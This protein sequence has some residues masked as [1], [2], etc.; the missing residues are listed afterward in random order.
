MS[1]T[2]YLG[3]E[4]VGGVMTHHLEATLPLEALRLVEP[5][6]TE[7]HPVDLWIGVED[8]LVYRYLFQFHRL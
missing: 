7:S 4:V 5:E 3:T 2:T 8:S 1:D 6:R